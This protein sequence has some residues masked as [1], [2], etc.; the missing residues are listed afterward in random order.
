LALDLP[1]I[2]LRMKNLDVHN[3]IW[4]EYFDE[5]GPT[6]STVA[7]YQFPRPQLGIEIR[8]WQK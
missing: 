3:E 6:R 8:R 5:H 1:A 2:H 4:A 7:V